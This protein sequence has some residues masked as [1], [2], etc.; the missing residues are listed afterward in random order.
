MLVLD[1]RPAWPLLHLSGAH[2]STRW[3]AVAQAPAQALA[4]TSAEALA[5]T[6]VE[7]LADTP[8]GAFA[9]VARATIVEMRW[10]WRCL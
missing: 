8:A 6:P 4:D 3:C 9:A 5:D 7:A 10:D 1:L 2:A